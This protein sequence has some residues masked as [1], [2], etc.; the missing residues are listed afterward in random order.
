VN[1]ALV[2]QPERDKIEKATD[3]SLF[4][5]A[6]AGSGKTTQMVK[7]IV[8]LV[9]EGTAVTRI[10]A[11]TFTEKAAAELRNRVRRALEK[12][13]AVPSDAESLARFRQAL[14]DLDSAPLGTI[15]SFA[16]RLIAENPISVMVPPGFEVQSELASTID[17][18]RQ[19]QQERDEIFGTPE[20]REDFDLLIGLGASMTHFEALV[21][22]LD[23]SWNLLSDTARIPNNESGIIDQ[24]AKMASDLV[25]AQS[26]C[27]DPEDRLL[28]HLGKVERFLQKLG[29]LEENEHLALAKHLQT[30]PKFHARLGAKGNWPEGS[31]DAMRNLGM[32]AD[33]VAQKAFHAIV[34]PALSRITD[35]FARTA[36]RRAQQRRLR[37][38]LGFHDLLV[39]ARDLMRKSEQVWKLISGRYDCVIVDEFQDTDGLQAEIVCRLVSE[40]F[41]PDA[42]WH[43]LRL[44]PGSLTT[45]GD[46]KQSIYRFRGA[47]IATYF[48]HRDRQPVISPSPLVTLT[49]NFRSSQPI[50]EWVNA[51]FSGIIVEEASVQPEFQ[52][53]ATGPF[54]S[55]RADLAGPHVGVLG[56]GDKIG[57]AE[58]ARKNEAE[59]IAHQVLAATGR[60]PG[61]DRWTVVDRSGNTPQALRPAELSD[62]CILLPTRRSLP[63]IEAAL[64]DS[65]IE[66]V[67][68]ASSIVYSTLEIQGLLMAA[69]AVAHTADAGS[70]VLALRSPVF[71]V[72]DDDLFL[73]HEADGPWSV[74]ADMAQP[75][76][77]HIVGR[78][79]FVLRRIVNQLHSLT[80]SDV[81]NLLA[82]EGLL[83]EKSLAV[84]SGQKAWW[85]R[86]RYVIDQAEAWYQTTGGSLRDYLKWAEI[87]Q[88]ESTRVREA[89]APETGDNAVRITTV[90][91]SKGLEYP[92]VFLGG[93]MSAQSIKRPVAV[94]NEREELFVHLGSGSRAGF[95]L[96]TDGYTDAFEAEKIYQLA[97]FRRLLYVACTRAESHLVIS[98][99]RYKS[100]QDH[101]FASLLVDSG[102][103]EIA[104]PLERVAVASLPVPASDETQKILQTQPDEWEIW[105][106]TIAEKSSAARSRSVTELVHNPSLE[107]ATAFF[108]HLGISPP[109]AKPL[110]SLDA[111]DSSSANNDPP[112]AKRVLILDEDETPPPPP[113][114][115]EREKAKHA[116]DSGASFGTALHSV[117]EMSGLDLKADLEALS[118][119][120]AILHGLTDPQTLVSA[121]RAVLE[122]EVVR[123]A[124]SRPHWLE[125]PMLFPFEG[126][127]IEG[128]ADLVFERLD[129]SLV[130]VDFKTD[131]EL[132]DTAL[133]S[134]WS[135]LSSYAV[136]LNRAT[137]RTAKEC[138]IIHIPSGGTA[139]TLKHE[140][141]YAV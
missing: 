85:R 89:I 42:P 35:H 66:F 54:A 136:I 95:E 7:R 48:Q 111:D 119:R 28:A 88:D 52:A 38:E 17:H 138:V 72:G 18:A 5:E 99:H 130:V 25:G 10:V 59:D 22:T 109:I 3:Q 127:S 103:G 120:A 84:G 112:P 131:R 81:L 46:P 68:E 56:T 71:G 41:D 101:A 96:E 110:D 9:A 115:G 64:R 6:G 79:L 27:T 33:L 118:A 128:I 44:R 114:T 40:E 129:G 24:L 75:D 121:A 32:E 60:L 12:T 69:R 78:A 139:T 55:S 133:H 20:L 50:V 37:G 30:F 123:E 21:S 43:E 76:S 14:D 122:S 97:E 135:Q 58:E 117:V 77:P 87:Q 31:V 36:L 126:I 108:E 134:Y 92:I 132:P 82:T 140:V 137:G 116:R 63:G 106:A 53:L 107:G 102:A 70:L 23:S 1:S 93:A 2:D 100:S 34:Q 62:I 98:Q 65:D 15:H 74:F 39:L 13:L 105:H 8:A 49:T 29:T 91:M 19:W 61:V 104:S 16:K 67:S 47:S 141:L 11:I 26:S 80:P 94:W 4:V 90:H 45:V 113:K 51:A 57:K 124:H 125:L 83:Y 86:L 73:W